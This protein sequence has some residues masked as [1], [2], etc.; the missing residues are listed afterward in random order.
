MPEIELRNVSLSFPTPGQE[1][2][3]VVY[4]NFDITI[5][6]GSFTVLLGPSGCGKS[7]FLNVINGL[8]KPTSADAVLIDGAD[9]REK[10]D[11]TRKM[12][13]IFQ[14]PRL[15]PWKTLRS[16]VEFGLRG[17]AVKP[18]AEWDAL[19]EKYFA[20]VGLTEYM[21]YYPHQVSGGMQQ[22]AAIVRAWVN[23]PEILL[24][25]EPFSHLDEITG[26]GLRRE[27]IELWTAEEERRTIVF[28][29]HNISEAV[30]LA[31]DIV[32][33]TRA[34]SSI[35]YRTE[36]GIPWPRESTADDVFMLEKELRR[37]FAEKAGIQV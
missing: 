15:L 17:L 22:R 3:N 13:Y 28:V 10:P 31:S 5:A 11:L 33:L 34:P 25:D 20:M 21:D 24:M 26:A 4:E 37:V 29:T 12:A 27:L 6:K 1:A 19:I 16:N 14:G 32:V 30:Q 36:V 23:E 8:L 9:I 18:K 7:T 2:R 35:C